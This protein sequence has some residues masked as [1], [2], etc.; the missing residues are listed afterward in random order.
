MIVVY[1]ELKEIPEFYKIDIEDPILVLIENNHWFIK[2][3]KENRS[4]YMGY[5]VE[6]KDGIFK[7]VSDIEFRDEIE[8]I[9]IIDTKTAQLY[10]KDGNI[11]KIYLN[12]G[13][14]FLEGIKPFFL[15]IYLDV[16]ELYSTVDIKTHYSFIPT[17]DGF[18]VQFIN[19]DRKFELYFKLF[20]EGNLQLINSFTEKE[21]EFDK[22][23]NS[24][25]W[26]FNIL[27]AFKGY[28]S[29]ITLEVEDLLKNFENIESENIAEGHPL[30]KFLLKRIISLYDGEKFRAGLFWFPQRWFRDELLTLIFLNFNNEITKIREKI[31]NFYIKNIE[32]IWDKNREE[33]YIKT[34]DT[35]PLL[36][37]ALDAKNIRKNYDLLITYLKMWQ[38]EFLK[39]IITLV[40]K[41]TWM[42]TK[43]R[44][45]AFELDM[46]YLR[47]LEKL[48]LFDEYKRYVTLLKAK[49]Y[50]NIYPENELISPNLFLGYFFN[51][52]FFEEYEWLQYFDKII[53]KFYLNWGGFS[54]EE[55]NSKYFYEYHTGEDP[56]SY[57][58]GDSWFFINNVALFVLRELSFK[59]Y[60]E[61]IN[62]IKEASLKNLLKMGSLGYM[63][64]LSSAKELKFEGCP[65]QLWSLSSLYM[66]LF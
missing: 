28:V 55:K 6:K 37:N 41:S 10:L 38:K 13:K 2:Q 9:E 44:V 65:V 39:D 45:N 19:P 42:D 18:Y 62:K 24:N 32:S 49:I 16:R 57:H 14:L 58:S 29:K 22:I 40:P 48:R 1:Q 8:R 5:W 46:I 27:E 59:K 7:V 56:K 36:I 63:S 52:T 51:K 61:I 3:F 25:Y 50:S 64:E 35:F 34:A 4:I 43:N 20:F 17:T 23:R 30:K 47:A 33:D 60:E 15:T 54:T 26:K 12:S 31:L 53:E 11:I 21:F 66:S